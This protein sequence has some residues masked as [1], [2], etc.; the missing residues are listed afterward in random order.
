MPGTK[1]KKLDLSSEEIAQVFGTQD[2]FN[3]IKA[4]LSTQQQQNKG[5]K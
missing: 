5:E 4:L 2:N 3:M 1:N